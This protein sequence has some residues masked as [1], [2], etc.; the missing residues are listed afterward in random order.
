MKMAKSIEEYLS[1]AGEWEECVR[2]LVDVLGGTELREE[3]KW[4][5]P[6]YMLNKKH[7]V[8]VVAF[9]SYCGLWFHQG[10]FLSDSNKVLI[11]AEK[12]KTR[13]QRQWRFKNL[14]EIQVNEDLIKA[15]VEEAIQNQKEGKGIK[16]QKKALIIPVELQR[17]L[18]S[19]DELNA[20]Y[21][22]MSHS[23]QREYADYIA[24]AK[25]DET[26]L[27]RLEKIIPMVLSRKGLN[28][29]YR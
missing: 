17:A 5:I 27:R 23:C 12:D 28:D 6:T 1:E 29:R 13:G 14:A 10:V 8:A 21:R 3:L 26:K 20:S 2:Y 4:G 24:E 7:V 19:N 16:P 15:Y 9:K 25:R 11:N 18:D 22:S